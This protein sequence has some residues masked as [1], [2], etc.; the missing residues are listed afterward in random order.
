MKL[1]YKLKKTIA[2]SSIKI[3]KL[4]VIIIELEKNKTVITKLK[5]K[6]TE[7]R[8]R[9]IKLPMEVHSKKLLKDI[10]HITQNK[11]IDDCLL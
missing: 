2:N 1:R 9:V 10:L 5:S 4:N 7:F 8:D 6:N 3:S 11:E